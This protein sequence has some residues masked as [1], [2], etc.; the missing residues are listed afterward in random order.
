[1]EED[2][3]A[4]LLANT[5]VSALV[6]TRIYWVERKQGAALPGVALTLIDGGEGHTQ[7][8]P[9][10]LGQY[11]VQ[12]DSYGATYAS[13]KA[14]ARAITAA[15]DGVRAGRLQGMFHDSSRDL[16]EAGS[17]DAER[18]FRTSSDFII[19]HRST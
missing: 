6:G 19:N 14:V 18:L 12:I 16:R 11:R 8:G 3:V 15:L 4:L 7:D 5:G 10:G 17:N 1:M 2:L 13:A 9:D